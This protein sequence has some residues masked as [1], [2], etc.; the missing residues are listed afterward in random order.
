MGPPSFAEIGSQKVESQLGTLQM[1]ISSPTRS[2]DVELGCS[3]EHRMC[4]ED[5]IR[6]TLAE[7]LHNN[8]SEVMAKRRFSKDLGESPTAIQLHDIRI[9]Y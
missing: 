4:C 5:G 8:K 6:M 7:R 2:V 3:R 9:S 1:E